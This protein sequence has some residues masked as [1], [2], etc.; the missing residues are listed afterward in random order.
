LDGRALARP[1]FPKPLVVSGFAKENRMA[2]ASYIVVKG[3][4]Y[5]DNWMTHEEGDVVEIDETKITPGENLRKLKTA[6]LKMTR[7]VLKLREVGEP[8]KAAEEPPV[9]QTVA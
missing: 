3:H 1:S 8:E 9:G 7:S 5:Y 4:T 2:K 6:E